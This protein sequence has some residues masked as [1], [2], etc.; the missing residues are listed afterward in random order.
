MLVADYQGFLLEWYA[1]NGRDL[2]WR[3]TR[4][5]WWIL[6][7]E[8]ML[9]QTQVARIEQRWPEFIER[10]PTPQTCA[11]APVAEL[12]GM[13]SGLGFNR[14]AVNL[15]RCAADITTRFGG[16]VP[17]DIDDLL[18]L[19]G[20]G[21]YTARAIR[22][23]AFE[24]DDAVLDTNVARIL[25]RTQGRTLK[26]AEAQN[27]ADDAVPSGDGWR[28]NQA[29][30]DLGASICT[31]N[32]PLCEVCPIAVRCRWRGND[33]VVDPAKG[34]AGVST[35]QS[36]FEGSDRQGRGRLVAAL[37][38]GPV[39]ETDTPTVMG[40]E[41]DVERAERVAATLVVDGLAVYLE[42]RYELP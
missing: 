39:D 38:D 30:L 9:Q 36:T 41:G 28:W 12:I 17:S 29:V 23:F 22:V 34:S 5:P 4:N 42:G 10:F 35:P 20:I 31:S 2:P 32:R 7:S 14:R 33:A 1:K 27:L 15:H 18:S 25:A 24:L 21:P 37:K 13:W 40:W 16:D 19:P 26:R 8:I 6:L 3:R 11:E